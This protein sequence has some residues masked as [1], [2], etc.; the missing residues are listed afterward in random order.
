MSNPVLFAAVR[1]I[2]ERKD[3]AQLRPRVGRYMFFRVLLV[4]L[5]M[6]SMV[7]INILMGTSFRL[8][9]PFAEFVLGLTVLIYLLSIGYGILTLRLKN[10]LLLFYIQLLGDLVFISFLVHLTGGAE[11]GYA[12]LYIVLVVAAAGV[13]LGRGAMIAGFGSAVLFVLTSVLGYFKVFPAILGQKVSAWEMMPENL[14]RTLGINVSAFGAAALLASF[15]AKQWQ[16]AGAQAAASR[17]ALLDLT[18]LHENILCFMDSGVIS[19]DSDNKVLTINQKARKICEISDDEILGKDLFSVLP[20]L[21]SVQDKARLQIESPALPGSSVPVEV[22]VTNLT[23]PEQAMSVRIYL[24][25]DRTEFDRMENEMRRAEK[26]A[27]I[28]RFA[29]GVA[30]EIRNPL[31]AIS[32][33]IELLGHSLPKDGQDARLMNNVIQEVERLDRMIGELL[34]FSRPRELQP[35]LL[36]LSHLVRRSVDLFLNQQALDGVVVRV[37]A[38]E[39]VTAFVDEEKVQQIIWNLL[40]NS[41]EA[42]SSR[43]TVVV[44]VISSDNTALMEISD[45][46]AGIPSELLDHIFEPFFTTKARGTGLGL[47]AVH[48]IVSEHKGSI[49]VASSEQGTTFRIF[50]PQHGNGRDRNR[51]A[52]IS[53][54][55]AGT[56]S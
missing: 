8:E 49:Q 3:P 55:T 54:S 11:S 50:F 43:G 42:M 27:M 28:G 16:K 47:A 22:T 32:G 53:S 25:S 23:R 20:A 46:G 12:A 34:D 40:R 18:A 45:T 35:S 13:D 36:D 14:V 21:A 31:A 4:T 5:L 7:L 9:T 38:A 44:R 10:L 2:L 30:H 39:P 6:A 37:E 51:A 41:T 1:E 33:S 56:I 52:Q 26:L 24:L 48:Q 15:L 29:A 19:T 17:K